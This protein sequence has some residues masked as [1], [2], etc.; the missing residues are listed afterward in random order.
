MANT[1]SFDL[2][3][4]WDD[5]EEISSA[6]KLLDHLAETAQGC[7]MVHNLDL[8]SDAP[9]NLKDDQGN[10]FEHFGALQRMYVPLDIN[11]TFTVCGLDTAANSYPMPEE[12]CIDKQGNP[13]TIF[14]GPG[15]STF[16][17]ALACRNLFN[18]TFDDF[19]H[20]CY[21]EGLTINLDTKQLIFSMG[22]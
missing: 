12:V 5:V 2:T 22:S 7:C 10:P 15:L 9:G 14:I 13:I 11:G 4:R 8:G 16:D 18:A 19:P 17:I 21:F 6:R 3:G 1:L 20:H